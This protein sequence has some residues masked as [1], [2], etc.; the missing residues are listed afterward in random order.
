MKEMPNGAD[1]VNNAHLQKAIELGVLGPGA[2]IEDL[3]TDVRQEMLDR[4]TLKDAIRFGL[5]N[6]EA[7]TKDLS[8]EIRD[9]VI[10]KNGGR[11]RFK[12]AAVL[13]EKKY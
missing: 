3:T 8:T 10:K 1:M 7:T 12:G 13:I 6:Q 2:K 4:L 9:E 11:Y 5:L